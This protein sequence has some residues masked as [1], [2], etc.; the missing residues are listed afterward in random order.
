MVRKGRALEK[1]RDRL[2]A[3]LANRDASQTAVRF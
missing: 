2:Q 3:E 1:E